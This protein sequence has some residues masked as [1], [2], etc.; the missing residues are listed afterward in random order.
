MAV[1]TRGGKYTVSFSFGCAAFMITSSSAS[2]S[3]IL[4]ASKRLQPHDRLRRPVRDTVSVSAT[5]PR[6][7]MI[8]VFDKPQP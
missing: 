8:V 6:F 3:W 2:L 7:T 4:P 5:V 1:G